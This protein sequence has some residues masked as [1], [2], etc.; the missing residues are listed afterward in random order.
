MAKQPFKAR[1]FE[2]LIALQSSVATAVLAVI[3]VMTLYF[4]REIVIPIALAILLSFVLAP[5][6]ALLQRTRL[7]RGIAVVSVV[8]RHVERLEFLDVMFGDRPALSPP[9]IFYQRM[10]AGDP[11][12]ASDEAEEFSKERSLGTYYYDEVALKRLQLAQADADHEN[13]RC[14]NGVCRQPL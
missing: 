9:E 6:V 12:E 14:G 2:E 1:T 10:L 13:Q 3:I 7:P 5:L 8:G 11:T 4:G